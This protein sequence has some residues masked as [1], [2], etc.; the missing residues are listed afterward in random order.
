MAMVEA[1]AAQLA[2][3]T[4]DNAEMRN[5]REGYF[6]VPDLHLKEYPYNI[7]LL[8]PGTYVGED[9]IL[10]HEDDGEGREH[11]L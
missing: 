10:N 5:E 7:L 2:S 1:R 11:T 9:G 3:T 6:F 8:I 4:T